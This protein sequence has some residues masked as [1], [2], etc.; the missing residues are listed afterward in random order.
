MLTSRPLAEDL[1]EYDF[2][3][4]LERVKHLRSDENG[5]V[6]FPSCEN[7]QSM[8]KGLSAWLTRS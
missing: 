5:V 2:V 1:D 7:G 3:T 4:T 6:K 8:K